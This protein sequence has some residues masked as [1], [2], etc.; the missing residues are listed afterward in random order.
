MQDI[1]FF[2]QHHSGLSLAFMVTLVLLMIVQF[3][4]QKGEAAQL[5]PAQV[6][7]LINRENAAIIDIRNTT[8]FA[9]GHIIGSTSAPLAEIDTK[10]KKLEKFKNK[11]IVVVCMLG[12]ESPKAN[13]ILSKLGFANIHTLQ[14][15]I[16][17]WRK[18]DMPLVKD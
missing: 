5:S 7:Q 14:G 17:A 8:Q 18:A 2:M 15:G 16:D 6:T 9:E 3:I 1:T 4:K 12:H 10:I 11:P 13:V